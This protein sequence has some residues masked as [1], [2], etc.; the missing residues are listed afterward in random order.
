MVH[1]NKVFRSLLRR[2]S[3]WRRR[4]ASES[5][6]CQI[7]WFSPDLGSWHVCLGKQ[8]PDFRCDDLDIFFRCIRQPVFLTLCSDGEELQAYISWRVSFSGYQISLSAASF[9]CGLQSHVLV[10]MFAGVLFLH[11]LFSAIFKLRQAADDRRKK[12]TDLFFMYSYF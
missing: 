9:F 1:W 3:I 7:C 11:C 6:A 5:M 10:R 12:T 8:L 4:R 2:R